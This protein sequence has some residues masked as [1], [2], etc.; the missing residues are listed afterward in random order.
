MPD[1]EEE[2]DTTPKPRDFATEDTDT[3][4]YVGVSPEYMTH[5]GVQNQPFAADGGEEEEREKLIQGRAAGAVSTP[6]E[7]KGQST[8]GGGSS[9]EL[10]YSHTS[11]ENVSPKE[12]NRARV[13]GESVAK[14][15]SQARAEHRPPPKKTAAA[16]ESNE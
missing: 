16:S 8:Q 7:H 12:V 6:T 11:G 3:S 10:V 13:H 5:A 4:A 14:K 15:E 9:T 1:R 2:R